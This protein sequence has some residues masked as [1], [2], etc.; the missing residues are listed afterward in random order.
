M[1]KH[2]V[3]DEGLILKQNQI[4]FPKILWRKALVK[5]HQGSHS[6]HEHQEMEIIQ[7]F[8]ICYCKLLKKELRTVQ[9]AKFTQLIILKNQLHQLH[10]P[11]QTWKKVSIDLLGP[12]PNKS[13]YSWYKLC[14]HSTNYAHAISSSKNSDISTHKTSPQCSQS[15][16]Q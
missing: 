15:N 12:M 6:W 4:T 9:N 3:S 2:T 8:V 10:T 14:S 7:P 16:L 11:K 5:A 13:M 1:K